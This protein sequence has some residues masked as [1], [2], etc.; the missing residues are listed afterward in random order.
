MMWQLVRTLVPYLSKPFRLAQQNYNMNI[1]GIKE[2]MARWLMCIQDCGTASNFGFALGHLFVKNE[3]HEL[4]KIY[5]SSKAGGTSDRP[6]RRKS[7]CYHLSRHPLRALRHTIER[8]PATNFDFLKVS[9][10]C[11]CI[12]CQGPREVKLAK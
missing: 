9:N 4:D 7:T 3:F 5:V 2:S 12:G 10:I 8:F 6:L 1:S 11:I